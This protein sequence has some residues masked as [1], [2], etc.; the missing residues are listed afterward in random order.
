[1]RMKL[2]ARYGIQKKLNISFMDKIANIVNIFASNDSVTIICEQL[3]SSK[4]RLPPLVQLLDDV[5]KQSTSTQ[6]M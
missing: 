2:N 5:Q 4:N 1:M 3:K 6:L